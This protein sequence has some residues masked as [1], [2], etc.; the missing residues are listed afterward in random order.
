LPG[1]DAKP[2]SNRFLHISRRIHS[3]AAMLPQ[4]LSQIQ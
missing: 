1:Y 3:V 2:V 4:H